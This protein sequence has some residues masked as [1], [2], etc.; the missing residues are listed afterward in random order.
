M[1]WKIRVILCWMASTSA[2]C[3]GYFLLPNLTINIALFNICYHGDKT[4]NEW[5]HVLLVFLRA[6]VLLESVSR[7][8]PFTWE[9]FGVCSG[10]SRQSENAVQSAGREWLPSV[11]WRWVQSN[12]YTAT[13][14]P[15]LSFHLFC[16][17]TTKCNVG[18]NVG[19]GRQDQH[20]HS[21]PRIACG[22]STG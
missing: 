5:V 17:Q 10:S 15:S 4:T 2:W 9:L 11:S 1:L 8:C 13:R 3:G 14:S 12:Q 18:F 21:C 7:A 22:A 6:K 20:L 16:K 19:F